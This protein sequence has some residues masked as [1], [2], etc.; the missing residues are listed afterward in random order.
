MIN[1]KH[2]VEKYNVLFLEVDYEENE[3]NFILN[4]Y[5]FYINYDYTYK[6][7]N[8]Y[9]EDDLSGSFLLNDFMSLRELRNTL[10]DVLDNNVKL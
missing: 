10:N 8:V 1:V 4:N 3:M 7:Y 2:L 6:L 5:K 9:L